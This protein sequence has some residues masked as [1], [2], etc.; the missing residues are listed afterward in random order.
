MGRTHVVF[1]ANT[2]A[3]VPAR[4]DLL[5]HSVVSHLQPVLLSGSLTKSNNLA[6]KLV[7][8]GD[9]GLAVW[10]AILVTPKKRGTIEA[11]S[12]TSTDAHSKYLYDDL[13]RAGNRHR[14][15]LHAIIMGAMAN[16]TA[17]SLW[18]TI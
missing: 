17:H 7:A 2:E 12:I 8:R 13:A 6:Y 4:H 16:N 15:S 10:L 1:A 9:G 14:E 18:E 11:L 3:A 5:R